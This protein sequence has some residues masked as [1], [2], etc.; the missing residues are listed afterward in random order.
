M[1]QQ[2]QFAIEYLREENR[3]LRLFGALKSGQVP[4]LAR[5]KPAISRNWYTLCRNCGSVG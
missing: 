3:V 5:Y 4:A 2:Q 1:N